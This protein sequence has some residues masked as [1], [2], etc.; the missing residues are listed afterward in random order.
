MVRYRAVERGREKAGF[1]ER[2]VT[3]TDRNGR[4]GCRL[5][6]LANWATDS[7]NKLTRPVMESV[8]GIDSEAYL[9]AYDSKT[10]VRRAAERAPEIDE[11]APAHG[12]K[13]VIYTTCFCNFNTPS[14]GLA[15]RAVLARNGVETAVVHPRCC[16]MP[17]LEEGDLGRVAE[18]AKATAAELGVW[19]DKGYDAI[20]L[21]P[22]CALMLKFEWPLIVPGDPAVERLARATFDVAEYIIDIARK[23]GLAPGLG[24]L[25]GGVALHIACHARAQNLGRKAAELLALVP[26]ADIEVIERCSGHGG[27]WG[28]RA[29][30]FA[31]AIKTGRPVARQALKA[32][33]RYLVSECPLAGPH[34]A[35]GMERLAPEGQKAPAPEAALHPIELFARAY[36]IDVRHGE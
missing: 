21:V 13:A 26:D 32:D 29:A 15:A 34:I 4:I 33:R 31:T 23:E 16:G 35:Q 22:S 24:P 7:G 3:E 36:G 30:N 12:R 5:S 6:G 20:A 2:Q 1:I 8:A 9:P 11:T 19:I 18:S 17:Q 25:D 28:V 14:I 27:A 10:L